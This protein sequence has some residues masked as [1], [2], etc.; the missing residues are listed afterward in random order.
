LELD[1]D[2]VGVD[3][4][5][6][7]LSGVIR[8]VETLTEAWGAAALAA[9]GDRLLDPDRADAGRDLRLAGCL[10][11]GADARRA[12]PA[13]EAA[14][15]RGRPTG[16]PPRLTDAQARQVRALRRSGESIG[17]VVAGFGVSRATIYRALGQDLLEA[18]PTQA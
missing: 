13:R 14:R 5:G 18:E 15:A 2:A 9:G 3:R 4:R 10:R 16:R 12:A 7:S 11:A 6:R 8:T 1:V 17:E